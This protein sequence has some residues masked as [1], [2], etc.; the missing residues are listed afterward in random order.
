MDADPAPAARVTPCM[1]ADL[2][3]YQ[4][5]GMRARRRIA[6]SRSGVHSTESAALANAHAELRRALVAADKE[7]HKVGFRIRA[8]GILCRI[9]G[10]RLRMTKTDLVAISYVDAVQPCLEDGR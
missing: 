1:G 10:S 7:R 5:I 8:D 4:E 3:E 9:P 6:R 2:V